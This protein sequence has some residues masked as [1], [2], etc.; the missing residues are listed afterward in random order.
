M[1]YKIV[2]AC[3]VFVNLMMKNHAKTNYPEISHPEAF[4]EFSTA[5]E[6]LAIPHV[7][8]LPSARHQF[9]CQICCF[10]R[11]YYRTVLHQNRE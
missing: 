4:D 9:G 8:C 5:K 6:T 2:S 11:K 3:S 7:I 10:L 1:V